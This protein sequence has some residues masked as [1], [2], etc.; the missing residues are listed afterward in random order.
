MSGGNRRHAARIEAGRASLN[1]L[2]VQ[3]SADYEETVV[4]VISPGGVIL[5]RVFYYTVP[6][7]LIGQR[8]SVDTRR[9]KTG[10]CESIVPASESR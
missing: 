6:S 5:R 2:P 3:H 4:T 7:R 8:P 1:P 10:D 9:A